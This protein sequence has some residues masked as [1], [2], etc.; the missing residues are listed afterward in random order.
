MQS[1]NDMWSE[2]QLAR[3]AVT[4]ELSHPEKLT[5]ERRR[6]E[7]DQEF[8]S[9]LQKSVGKPGIRPHLLIQMRVALGRLTN[10]HNLTCGDNIARGIYVVC[11][12]GWA[13]DESDR[14][15]QPRFSHGFG[16]MIDGV[17]VVAPSISSVTM[18]WPRETLARTP[19]RFAVATL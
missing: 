12:Y 6:F 14:T 10:R 19:S 1:K 3:A 13:P 4:E 11:V 7:K 17:P 15:I 18:R 9:R 16:L 5:S 2:S 8:T